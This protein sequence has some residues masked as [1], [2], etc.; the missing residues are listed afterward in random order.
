MS[1]WC[2]QANIILT[3]GVGTSKWVVA[4]KV[5]ILI[6]SVERAVHPSARESPTWEI[7]MSSLSCGGCGGCCLGCR[8]HFSAWAA[9]DQRAD[10]SR[11]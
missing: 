1:I 5:V 2:S 8:C 4:A 7:I 11:R 3:H 6:W 9:Y 10:G